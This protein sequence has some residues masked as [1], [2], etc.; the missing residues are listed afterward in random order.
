MRS[1]LN[2]SGELK[3]RKLVEGDLWS[4]RKNVGGREERE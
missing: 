3:G 2:E 4:D 1:L